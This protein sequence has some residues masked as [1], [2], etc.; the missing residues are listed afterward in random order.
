MVPSKA[1]IET[2]EPSS[3]PELPPVNRA[4]PAQTP[5]PASASGIPIAGTP[6][7]VPTQTST[8]AKGSGSALRTPGSAPEQHTAPRQRHLEPESAAEAACLVLTPRGV[9]SPG[10]A[11]PVSS[12]PARA[13]PSSVSTGPPLAL[14]AALSSLPKT[15]RSEA[16]L[17]G[18]IVG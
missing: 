12:E 18:L 5:V 4:Q 3:K 2:L 16:R 10:V 17:P 7:A 14:L 13:G 9:V 6:Q 8:A 15:L 11:D 1:P